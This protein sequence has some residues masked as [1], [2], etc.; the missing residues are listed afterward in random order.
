MADDIINGLKV[1]ENRGWTWLKGL[2]WAKEDPILIGI[3]SSTNKFIYH[4]MGE[5][6]Q[7]V[8]CE[9]PQMDE[10]EFV[11]VIGLLKE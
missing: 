10:P 11:M 8:V 5:D 4:G 3:Q 9:N 6:D 7:K 2:D 1:L